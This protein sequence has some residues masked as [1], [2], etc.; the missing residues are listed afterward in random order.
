MSPK[1]ENDFIYE[2]DKNTHTIAR[3]WTLFHYLVCY[4]KS[5]GSYS[6]GGKVRRDKDA[7]FFGSLTIGRLLK[8]AQIYTE[9]FYKSLLKSNKKTKIEN[10]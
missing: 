5:V 1:D 8:K 9:F 3:Y 4:R 6:T 2:S 10:I 7:N